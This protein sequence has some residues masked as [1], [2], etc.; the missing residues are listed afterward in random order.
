MHSDAGVQVR[1]LEPFRVQ[2][3]TR[4]RSRRGARARALVYE[5]VLVRAR[6]SVYG[7][8][9]ERASALAHDARARAYGRRVR[10]VEVVRM[11][12]AHGARRMHAPG[13][14]SWASRRR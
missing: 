2:E 11:R 8:N 6:L 9:C 12:V 3:E 13:R 4:V 1:M 14:A 5:R 7:M 10:V